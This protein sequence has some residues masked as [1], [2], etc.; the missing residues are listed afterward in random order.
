MDKVPTGTV[1]F[2]FTDIER[3]TAWW[4]GHRE[5]MSVAVQRHDAVIRRAV[6]ASG[7]YVFSTAGDSFAAAFARAGDAVTA[8]F[9][10]QRALLAERWPHPIEMR[11]RMGVHTGDAEERADNYFGPA[12]NRAARIMARAWGGQVLVS[13]AT[14]ELS[15]DQLPPG[16]DLV[17]LGEHRLASLERAERLFQ[18]T[19]PGLVRSFPRLAGTEHL[20]R[21]VTSFVGRV[22]DL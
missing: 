14:T 1:S 4:E 10:A 16:V 9:E 7:G 15:R 12:V 2:F 17:D 18:V 22:G 6:E 13:L 11:V 20:P 8:A 21:P 19:G 5:L 3:S